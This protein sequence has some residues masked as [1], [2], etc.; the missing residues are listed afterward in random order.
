MQAIKLATGDTLTVLFCGIGSVSQSLI[1]DTETYKDFPA[2]AALLSDPAATE[3]I[4]LS[5]GREDTIYKGYTHLASISAQPGGAY[6][7]FLQ[8]EAVS[9]G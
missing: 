7:V 6:R 3:T 8:K 5:N 4:V 1:F 2:L 9:N